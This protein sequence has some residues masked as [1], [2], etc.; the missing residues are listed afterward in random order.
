[1][2]TLRTE[3]PP[4]HQTPA[5]STAHLPSAITPDALAELR[6]EWTSATLRETRRGKVK[7]VVTGIPS[8]AFFQAYKHRPQFKA[9]VRT[10]GI[11]LSRLAKNQW[12]AIAWVNRHTL[13]AFASL[14]GITIPDV[15]EIPKELAPF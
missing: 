14:E 8:P 6:I 15:P 9:A 10:F 7:A 3:I 2:H 13:P 4:T 1:M 5:A 11:T 12:E